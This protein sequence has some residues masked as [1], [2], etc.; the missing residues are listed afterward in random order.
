M[1]SKSRGGIRRDYRENS[2]GRSDRQARAEPPRSQPRRPRTSNTALRNYKALHRSRIPDS[3]AGSDVE[4]KREF[5]GSVFAVPRVCGYWERGRCHNQ[6]KANA[7]TEHALP[8]DA[9][10]SSATSLDAA[11]YACSQ[12]RRVVRNAWP[13]CCSTRERYRGN[14][15]INR[16]KS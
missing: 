12:D 4:W 14:H 11:G 7:T 8:T 2:A 16:T 1:R 13:A 6:R 5:L 10:A 9:S 3:R 15:E